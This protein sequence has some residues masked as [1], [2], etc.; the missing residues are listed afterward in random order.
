MSDRTTVVTLVVTRN[1]YPRIAA[2]LAPAVADGINE[3]V[4][5]FL[6]VADPITPVETGYMRAH[7][8]IAAASPGH[9]EA[10]V[11]YNAEYSAYVHEGT[12]H[13]APQPWARDA[14]GIV[15]PGHQARMAQALT[16]AAGG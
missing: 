4:T 7:K 1:T 6:A 11:T 16:S 10:T 15:A 5:E 14:V 12:I 9:L 13:Q 2:R 3:M 8:T